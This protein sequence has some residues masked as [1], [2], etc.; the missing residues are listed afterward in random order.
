MAYLHCHSCDWS[1]D[2]F[3]SFGFHKYGYF[4]R[5]GYN[6]ISYFL[7]IVFS[8]KYGYWRPQRREFDAWLAKDLGWKRNDPH[9]WWLIWFHFKKM[10]KSFKRQ[11]WW[12]WKSWQK[13]KDTAICPQC[14]DRN[15]D[16]D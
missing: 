16:I 8:W 10:L 4:W 13:Y 3:W 15:F 1:Q 12:T 11:K 9:S 6:P 2:D 7:S 14:G 5:W